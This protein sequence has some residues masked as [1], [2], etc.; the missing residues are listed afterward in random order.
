MQNW[1]ILSNIISYTMHP[2]T[3]TSNI[4][5][6]TCNDHTVNKIT[7]SV[8]EKVAPINTDLGNI[9]NEEYMDS[10]NGIKCELKSTVRFDESTEIATTY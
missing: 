10:Y 4:K 9:S 8:K 6:N 7:Y 5:S 3:T 2:N 1:S